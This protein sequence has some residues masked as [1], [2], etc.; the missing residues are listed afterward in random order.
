MSESSAPNPNP[1]PTVI[2]TPTAWACTTANA[3]ALPGLGTIAAG[4]RIGYAQAALALVGLILSVVGLVAHL[5]R[6]YR[7]GE[8]PQ[9][10]TPALWLALAG[11]GAFALAW[12]WALTSSIRLHRKA[13]RAPPLRPLPPRLS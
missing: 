6:W 4:R 11:V 13:P 8:L 3:L 9:E 1:A 5:E 2:D 7:D 10:V 12:F